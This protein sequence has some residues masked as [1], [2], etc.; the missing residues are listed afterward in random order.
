METESLA[1]KMR[2]GSAVLEKLAAMGATSVTVESIKETPNASDARQKPNNQDVQTSIESTITGTRI[3]FR[4]PK[5]KEEKKEIW[6]R[7][8]TI[9]FVVVFVV[10][11]GFI[12]YYLIRS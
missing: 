4:M 10:F 3:T 8:C 5:P 6:Q 12:A 11:L 7:N 1:E 2:Q 9:I